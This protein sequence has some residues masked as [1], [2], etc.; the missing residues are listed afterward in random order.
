MNTNA[1]Q[2]SLSLLEN[3]REDLRAARLSNGSPV[4]DVADLRQYIYE[5]MGRIR[6]NALLMDGLGGGDNGY[7]QGINKSNGHN[8]KAHREERIWRERVGFYFSVARLLWADQVRDS[9]A[10][11]LRFPGQWKRE[12]FLGSFRDVRGG[13]PSV[14][15]QSVGLLLLSSLST[16]VQK[17]T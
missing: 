13:R 5:E 4:L 6:T 2:I 8:G 3:L 9:G 11:R 7:G 16:V 12:D 1:R 15:K 17:A 14:A 10:R